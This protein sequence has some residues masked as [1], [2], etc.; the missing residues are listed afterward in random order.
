VKIAHSS[1]AQVEPDTTIKL[2]ATIED[3]DKRV[4][5]VVLGFRTGAKGKFVTVAGT[6]AAGMFRAQIPAAAVKPPLV[7]YYL[8]ATDRVGL[9]VATRGD[10]QAPLRIAVPEP[11]GGVLSSP[12]FWVPVGVLV[13]GGAVATTLI[14][15]QQRDTSRVTIRVTE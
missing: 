8:Q 4:R 15:T 1:P 2:S 3:P 14:L 5:S 9:P 10:A 13:V 11:S 12:W 6:Y 7:E